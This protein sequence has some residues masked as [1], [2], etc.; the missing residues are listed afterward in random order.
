MAGCPLWERYHAKV[1]KVR[2]NQSTSDGSWKVV[3]VEISSGIP[4]GLDG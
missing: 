1:E 3:V 2:I 4:G